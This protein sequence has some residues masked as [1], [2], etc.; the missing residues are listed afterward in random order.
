MTFIDLETQEKRTLFPGYTGVFVHTEGMTLVYWT[1]EA[2]APLPDHAHPHEQVTSVIEGQFELTV[3][4]ETRVVSPGQIA[5]IPSNVVHSGRAVTE[6][7][8]IDVFH[9]VREEYR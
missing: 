3:A 9:P 5:V 8:L 7:M 2:G 6:C 1:I 4:G